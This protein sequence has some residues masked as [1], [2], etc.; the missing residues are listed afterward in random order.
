MCKICIEYQKG[1]L[2]FEEAM[3]NAN[4]MSSTD[5]HHEDVIIML[6]NDNID[7]NNDFFDDLD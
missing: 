6:I 1:L 2:T 7:E 5:P 3:I 4:E